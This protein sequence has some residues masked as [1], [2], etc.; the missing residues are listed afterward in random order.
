MLCLLLPF[1]TF[2]LMLPNQ[3]EDLNTYVVHKLYRMLSSDMTQIALTEVGIWVIGEFGE[4]LL[5][6]DAEAASD[7]VSEV[8]VL[9][10]LSKA[11]TIYFST[12]RMKAMVYL[13]API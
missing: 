9:N 1:T 10:L 6:A 7:A 11:M 8:E 3:N 4:R 5:T 2:S 12:E 13:V